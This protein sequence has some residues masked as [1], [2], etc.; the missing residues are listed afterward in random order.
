MAVL[1]AVLTRSTLGDIDNAHLTGDRAEFDWVNQF[2]PSPFANLLE[3]CMLAALSNHWPVEANGRSIQAQ[4]FGS[5]LDDFYFRIHVSPQR[6]DMGSVA[7]VQ[8]APV[9]VWNAWLVPQTL[10]EISEPEDGLELGGQPGVPLLFAALQERSWDL[11]V[12]PDGQPSVDARIEWVF[13]NGDTAGLRITAT[14][15]I[16]WPF[17]PDWSESVIERLTAATDMLQSESGVSQRRKLRLA[18]RRE[19]EALT[20]VEGRERQFLDLALHAWSAKVWALPIWPDIQLLTQSVPAGALSIPCSTAWLDFRDGGL[21]MLRGEDA[22][23]AETV[24]IETVSLLGLQLKRATQHAWP[25]GSR[26]YPVRTAQLI[27][28]PSLS[29]VADTLVSASVRFQVV[30]PSDWAAIMPETLYRGWPVWDARPDES[31]DLSHSFERLLSVLDNGMALPLMSDTADRGLTLLGQ[32]WVEQGRASRAALRSFIHAMCGRQKTVWVPTHMDDLTLI[33]SVTSLATTLDIPNI[34][35]TRLSNGK[36]GRRDIRI[37]LHDGSVFMRRITS[38]IE[39][40]VAVERLVLD[41]A[42]G[43][44]VAPQQVARIS[45]MVLCRFESDTQEIEHLTDSEGVAI[46]ATVFREERD[47]EL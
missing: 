40:N 8:T 31:E 28:Q 17:V 14:R 33:A 15:I 24:E 4:R 26:L 2:D 45:W 30:E 42:L 34:G 16:A 9:Y 1:A 27:E 39:L 10:T 21:A 12:R 20:Y 23:T 35:Y 18:P 46:W 38:S 25:I 7:S 5:F 47:D 41:S 3:R 6:L 44:E 29:K 32:R 19:F 36:P 13:A 43:L 37:E 22:F 11:S